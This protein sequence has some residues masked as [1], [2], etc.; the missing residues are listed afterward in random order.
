[1]ERTPTLSR[2]FTLWCTIT[3]SEMSIAKAISVRRAARKDRSDAMRTNVKCEEK[4]H[5]SATK[6]TPAARNV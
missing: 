3:Y 5:S 6:V 4:E 2:L 1:M